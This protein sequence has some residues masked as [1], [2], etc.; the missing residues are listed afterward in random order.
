MKKLL[1]TLCLSLCTAVNIFGC[2]KEIKPLT[3]DDIAAYTSQMSN[4]PLSGDITINGVK[5]LS[6]SPNTSLYAFL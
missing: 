4:N 2:S 1:I 5:Y 6:A 3:P